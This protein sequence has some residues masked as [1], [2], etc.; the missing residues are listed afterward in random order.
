MR[1]YLDNDVDH[2]CAGVLHQ[3]GHEV[4]TTS[5]AG[6]S[7]ADDDEQTVYATDRKAVLVTHDREFTER[8]K[9]NTIG[10][11]VRL[12]CE[13]PDGPMLLARWLPDVVG[14]LERHV[15]VV[16][17]VRPNSTPQFIKWE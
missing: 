3:A 6:R 5:E 10:Q 9:R 4:F 14:L 1:F 7:D 12:D 8:R 13:Q 17:E 11:H 15:D 2:R 16:I